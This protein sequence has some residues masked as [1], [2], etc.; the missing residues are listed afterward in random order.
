VARYPDVV[1]IPAICI[2]S[3]LFERF[4]D[5]AGVS[6]WSARPAELRRYLAVMGKAAYSIELRSSPQFNNTPIQPAVT[7]DDPKQDCLTVLWPYRHSGYPATRYSARRIVFPVRHRAP[8]PAS[9][10]VAARRV[11]SP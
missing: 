2:C 9:L 10:S 11:T 1:S 8:F 4:S 6:K 7:P 3:C 5:V